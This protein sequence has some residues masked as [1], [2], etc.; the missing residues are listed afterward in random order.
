MRLSFKKGAHAVLSRAA[1]RKFGASPDFLCSF[2]GSLHFLRLSLMKGAH[3]VLSSAACRKFGVSLVFREMWDTEG[4]PL[5]PATVPTAPYGCSTFAQAY[6]GLSFRPYPL[7]IRRDETGVS[8]LLF[9]FDPNGRFQGKSPTSP[10]HPDPDFL[11]RAA[12]DDHV[13]G[14]P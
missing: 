1:Y 2:V 7:F 4:L 3:A 6:E 12:S 11:F 10:C 8:N 5:K 14:S 9:V 13:C